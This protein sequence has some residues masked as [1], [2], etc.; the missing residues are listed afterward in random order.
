[1]EDATTGLTWEEKFL[2]L[3]T[4]A[5]TEVL[6]REVLR[7]DSYFWEVVLILLLLPFRTRACLHL[8]RMDPV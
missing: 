8:P 6:P 4:Y 5:G 3:P 2:L 7:P 1:M